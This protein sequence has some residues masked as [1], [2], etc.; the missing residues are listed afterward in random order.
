[1]LTSIANARNFIKDNDDQPLP[2]HYHKLKIT[3][4]AKKIG[5]NGILIRRESI[6]GNGPKY[7]DATV[8]TVSQT[9]AAVSKS[10]FIKG[11]FAK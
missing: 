9:V 4:D 8:R 7:D 3:Y 10:V 2:G 1:M 5:T 11:L 6:S